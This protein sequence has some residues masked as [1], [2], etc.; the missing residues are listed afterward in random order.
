[1]YHSVSY[2]CN[3]WQCITQVTICANKKGMKI[4]S[5][6]M[7]QAS[8]PYDVQ[9]RWYTFKAGFTLKYESKRVKKCYVVLLHSNIMLVTFKEITLSQSKQYTF[10][11][12]TDCRWAG[13]S[14][15]SRRRR[16]YCHPHQTDKALLSFLS[17]LSKKAFLHT[18]VWDNLYTWSSSLVKS[19]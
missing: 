18:K 7:G 8:P 2:W 17:V 12:P 10:F 15:A 16:W 9:V 19:S 1:M 14:S 11:L 6:S 4:K 13:W 3:V 5:G